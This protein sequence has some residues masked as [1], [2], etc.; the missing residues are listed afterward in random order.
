MQ[1]IARNISQ[2]EAAATFTKPREIVGSKAFNIEQLPEVTDVEFREQ[3][4]SYLCE[5][6]L[7]IPEFHY[8]L[9]YTQDKNGDNGLS[10]RRGGE[11]MRYKAQRAVLERQMRSDPIHRELAEEYALS[12]LDSDL[13][14]AGKGDSVVW[15]SPPGPKDEGYGDYGFVFHGTMDGKNRLGMK[16]V[17]IEGQTVEKANNFLSDV[18]GEEVKMQDADDFLANPVLLP[19]SLHPTLLHT[20]L[21][22]HFGFTASKEDQEIAEKVIEDLREPINDFVALR[23]SISTEKK[24]K[25]LYSLENYALE[26]KEYYRQKKDSLSEKVIYSTLERDRTPNLAGLLLTHS[27]EPPKAAGSCGSTDSASI[28][29]NNPLSFM[30]SLATLLRENN[31]ETEGFGEACKCI[32]KSDNH[33]HCP[34]CDKKYADE[35]SRS[36]EQRTKQCG[37]GFKFG[38]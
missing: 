7:S 32:N 13:A 26:R 6:R 12:K 18:L 1:E 17:R 3:I 28:M 4:V 31:I 25:A 27:Y 14:L 33:Y 36:Q 9:Y 20:K 34:G 35:T 19:F 5:Y 30:S 37:C 11:L 29:S 23:D 21:R 38:C 10:D 8:D 15:I 22:E 24:I 2:Y 16:A